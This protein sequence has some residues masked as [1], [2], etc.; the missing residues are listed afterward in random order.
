M[1][2]IEFLID[3]DGKVIIDGKEFTGDACDLAIMKFARA[4]GKV[5]EVERKDDY[6]REGEKEEERAQE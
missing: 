5:E 2:D 6:Y 3:R 4:I 1:A